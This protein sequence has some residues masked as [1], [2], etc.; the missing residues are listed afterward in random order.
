M[1][2]D[3]TYVDESG[4]IIEEDTVEGVCQHNVSWGNISMTGKKDYSEYMKQLYEFIQQYVVENT[5]GEYVC[6]SCG[7]CLDIRKYIQDGVFDEEKGFVTFSMP[8]EANIEDLPE[9]EAYQFSIKIMDKNIEKIASSVGIP[10]FTGNATTVKWRRKAIIKSTIDMVK[11]NNQMLGKGFKE[12]NE[13]KTRMYGISKSISNLFVFDMENNIFQTSSKDK[14]Q[15]QFKMLK[16]N[17]ITTYIMI[18]MILELNESQISFF[19]SDKKNMCDITVFDKV[20]LSLF[21]GLRIKK[22]N[23]TDTVDITKYKIL[24]Y[25][26]YM[27]SCRI[28]RHRLWYSAHSTEKNI[29]K[30]IPIVQK[31]IVHTCVDIINSILENSFQPKVQY[32]FEIF[33]VRFY[34]KL[35][36]IFGDESYYQ[37]LMDQNK[38]SYATARKR[39]HL[40]LVPNESL[41]PYTYDLPKWR[42]EV[43]AKYFPKLLD[44][45]PINLNGVSNLSNCQSGEFHKWK[46]IENKDSLVCNRCDTQMKDL[47]YD[48]KNS[49][50]I[51]EKYKITQINKMAQKICRVDGEFHQYVYEEKLKKNI[52]LKCKNADDHIYSGDELQK[53]TQVI[54]Q[55]NSNR[56]QKYNDMVKKYQT[57]E[58]EETAHIQ[59][60]IDANIQNMKKEYDKENPYK[61]IDQ[62]INLLQGTIGNEIKGEYPI[63]LK[64]NTY[65]IDHDHNGHT[66]QEIII[67]ESDNKIFHKANHPFF[68]TDVIY[69][70]DKTGGRID[71]FYDTMTKKLLGYKESTKD[72]VE[73]KNSDKRIKIN[74]SIYNKLRLL[75]YTSEFIN[76][77]EQFELLKS[78][79]KYIE[80]ISSASKL[81]DDLT[82]QKIYREIVKE[83]SFHRLHNLKRTLLEFQR[84]FNRIMNN[85]AV[86]EQNEINEYE[87]NK[88]DKQQYGTVEKAGT[89][90]QVGKF[91]QRE[92]TNYFS[93]KMNTL[94]GKYEKKIKN[95]SLKDKSGKNKIFSHWKDITQGIQI[96]TFDDKYFNFE[97]NL[98]ETN[99]IDK[100][101][102][103]SNQ[104]LYYIIHEFTTLFHY[105]QNTFA[106]TNICNF[107]VEFI[108]RV[109]LRYNN[110]HLYTNNDIKRFMYVLDS[111]SYMKEIAEQSAPTQGF[112][113]EYV[114]TDE[115]PTE[116]DLEKRIDDDEEQD[117]RDVDEEPED[118]EE[119]V[120]SSYD[121]HMEFEESY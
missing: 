109:F 74:Y 102:Q 33:R 75:G 112:Y 23:T 41:M 11:Q 1:T 88:P 37:L 4:K 66:R 110:E 57:D 86:Y 15:E 104:I 90:A 87:K 81:T 68:K 60:I 42:I 30:M 5:Q 111:R 91:Y 84:I 34:T 10:Y 76:I 39:G 48:A 59:Q 105:N 25:L 93:E 35:T 72:F 36:S 3:L 96:G 2:V 71:V 118:H 31:Y 6:K 20:Y 78:R 62:F 79:A 117:A 115:E 38:F 27:L 106:K 40:K 12:R 47:K 43:P 54:D 83:I 100:Y 16:R 92:P 21:S 17:N 69:Y 116:E 114:D 49:A 95:I 8:M 51:L 113:E 80:T 58:A 70:I 94:V 56:R 18:Y 65:I 50:Q 55:I 97:S 121:D 44:K 7:F 99:M 9:Y 63:Y 46:F 85:Y 22:N 32:I 67:T 26:I 14:D 24:C 61:F 52:C 19:I 28:A 89:V 107:L 29:Q 120:A 77:S 98:I 13:N 103:Q 101:D 119:G 108:D 82:K 53:I 64:N 73:I 45:N